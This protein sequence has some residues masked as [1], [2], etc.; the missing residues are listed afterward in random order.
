MSSLLRF[1]IALILLAVII[2]GGTT[3][4]VII[5]K[6]SLLDS[7]YMTFLTI[8][9]VGFA[10]VHPLSASGR[11]FTIILLIFSV[12]TLGYSVTA[13]IGYL[14][15]G[16][17]LNAVRE[18]RMARILRRLR[19]H[20]ILCGAGNVGREVALEFQRNGVKF[21]VV[22]RE[23]SL[24]GLSK[25]ES[26]LFI[27]GNAEDDEIL[28]NAGIGS[29]RGL[30]SALPRDESNLFVV[31]TARQLNPNLLIIAQASE[32]ITER[33]LIKAGADRVVSPVQIA[34][35]RMASLVLRPSVVS[36]LEVMVRG[37]ELSMRLEEV[38]IGS[39]SPLVGKNL[40]EAGIG[41]ETGAIVVGINSAEGRT[42]INPTSNTVLSNIILGS[43]DVLIALGSEHQIALLRKFVGT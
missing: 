38:P 24:S 41:Q 1:F 18:R 12:F 28:I 13:F 8:T 11:Q 40:R 35:Q 2:V 32:E 34:G 42:R 43:G 30:V 16:Q 39:D 27:E 5:E 37:G 20:F 4:Y 10:E 36:F 31:F 15:E 33:K 26:I 14:F 7:L 17:I 21:V 19:N 6:W 25:D 22:D 9:T 23:P 3:G 29:A